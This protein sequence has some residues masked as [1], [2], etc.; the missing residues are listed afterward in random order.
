MSRVQKT[1]RHI[2]NLTHRLSSGLTERWSDTWLD[3]LVALAGVERWLDT[4]VLLLVIARLGGER[5]L[6]TSLVDD[7]SYYLSLLS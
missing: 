2:D 7:R 6:D 1:V 3:S 5:W 4:S